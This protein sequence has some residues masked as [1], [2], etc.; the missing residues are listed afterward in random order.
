[1]DSFLQ[2]IFVLAAAKYCVNAALTRRVWLMAL[3]AAVMAVT[4][5]AVHPVVIGWRGDMAEELLVNGA[6]VADVALLITLEAV[7]GIFIS[8]FVLDNYFMP[9]HK[10]RRSVFVLKVLPGVVCFVAAAYFES[11]FFRSFAGMEFATGAA[12][13]GCIVFAVVFGGSMAASGLMP[14][15]SVKLE[16][17]IIL[18]MAIL[19]VGL[20]VGASV[21]SY[22]TSGGH[23]QVETA[24]LLALAAMVGTGV[25]AG[26]GWHKVSPAVRGLWRR[27][28]ARRA[29]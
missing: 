28:M 3:Y 14:G 23:T 9:S 12:L 8:V 15:E 24:P 6:I 5:F 29:D 13:Y 4:A 18:D 27:L 26:Y 7:A 22:N 20:F 10:R 17:R 16:S 21:T 1:M 25:A 19:F 2:F 11:L